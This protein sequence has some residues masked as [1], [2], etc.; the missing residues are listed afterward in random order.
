MSKKIVVLTGSPRKNGNSFAM[1]DAFIKACEGKG[2]EVARFDTAFMNVNDCVA[3]QTCYRNEKAC[4][5]ND[6]F[7]EIASAIEVADSVVFS[8]PVYWFGVPAS[9][10]AVIDKFY[11]FSVGGKVY[12]MSGKN[13]ALITCWEESGLDVGDGVKF[14]YRRSVSFMGWNSVGEV[15][16]PGIYQAGAVHQTD[17]VIQSAKLADLI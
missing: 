13:T 17:G 2:Y 9:L 4:S 7:N 15:A 12:S 16:I 3:C 5:Q 10:K 8:C 11:A 1:T 6:D 14:T